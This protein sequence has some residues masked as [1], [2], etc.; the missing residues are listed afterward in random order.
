[1]S[2]LTERQTKDLTSMVL[3]LAPIPRPGEEVVYYNDSFKGRGF[4]EGHGPDARPHIRNQFN[5]TTVL[6]SFDQLR[7]KDPMAR[8][9]AAW[10]YLPST[11]KVVTPLPSE[12]ERFESLLRRIIP[13][14]PSYLD[15]IEEVWSRGFEV[16]LVGGTVRDVLAGESTQDVDLVTTMPLKSAENLLRGM[17]RT[18]PE[19]RENNGY[20]R[21]GG[22]PASHDPFIDL[23]MFS[24][25]STGDNTSL[26]G[27]DFARD[28]AHRDFSC[29]AI[30]YEPKN[31][32]LIDPTG[33]GISN[34]Q[35]KVLHL[36]CDPLLRRPVNLAQIVIRFFKFLSRDFTATEETCASIRTQFIPSFSS[37]TTMIRINYIRTQIL[38]K[39]PKS[40]HVEKL[41]HFKTQFEKFGSDDIWQEYVEPYT[42]EILG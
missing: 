34:A 3:P 25:F 7:A 35:T 27:A 9:G 31:K 11:A 8:R 17:Y 38:S 13:P 16:F 41:E 4:L 39:C 6:S 24:T 5:N 37:M 15:L 40:S 10:N 42:M 21:I 26:F 12:I 14:G 18:D 28:V 36:V 1:M 22:T 19:I 2:E 32:A 29:N 23:K 33:E 20:V 30:Y